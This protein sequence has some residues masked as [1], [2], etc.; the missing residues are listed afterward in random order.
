V[1]TTLA[2]QKPRW[3]NPALR[4]VNSKLEVMSRP[5]FPAGSIPGTSVIR[6][7]SRGAKL[8]T[9]REVLGGVIAFGIIS[10]PSSGPM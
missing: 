7:I 1:N 5:P 9:I 4:F 6:L 3:R 10:G 8:P 2:E